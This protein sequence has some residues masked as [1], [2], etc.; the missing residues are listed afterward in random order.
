M[1]KFL[2]L[3]EPYEFLT[4]IQDLQDDVRVTEGMVEAFQENGFVLIRQLLTENEMSHVRKCVENSKDI[5]ENAYG[6]SIH[7]PIINYLIT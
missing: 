4:E 5:E 7:S 3:E 6:R 1:S 2:P